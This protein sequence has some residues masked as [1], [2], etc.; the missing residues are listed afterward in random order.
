M[1]PWR[2]LVLFSVVLV[3]CVASIPD[4]PTISADLAAET[5]RRLALA[6][7]AGGGGGVHGRVHRQKI[8]SQELLFS[9][10]M[11]GALFSPRR[12]VTAAAACGRR[13]RGRRGV[14]GRGRGRLSCR[15]HRKFSFR[16]E[17]LLGGRTGVVKLCM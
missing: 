4:D 17:A 16:G 12:I 15:R 6:A 9:V 11:I 2:W 8:L 5:A 10:P 3:G 7:A 13:G 14:S 1:T